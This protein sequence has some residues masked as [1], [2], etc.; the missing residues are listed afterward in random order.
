MYIT[1]YKINNSYTIYVNY[2]YLNECRKICKNLRQSS[3]SLSQNKI[4]PKK[5]VPRVIIPLELGTK[6]HHKIFGDG[7]VVDLNNRGHI[8][9]I[10]NGK[11]VKFQYPQAFEMGF[12]TKEVI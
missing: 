2:T 9:V 12:L 11:T 1:S 10:F 3:V 4:Q 7:K 5:E 8:S 6:V